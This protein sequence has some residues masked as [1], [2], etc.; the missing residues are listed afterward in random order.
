MFTR[1]SLV[2]GSVLTA[3]ALAAACEPPF[4]P[5]FDDPPLKKPVQT[6]AP[7]PQVATVVA[8]DGKEETIEYTVVVPVLVRE[9]FGLRAEPHWVPDD[10]GMWVS[11]RKTPTVVRWQ[12]K[13]ITR[14][15]KIDRLKFSDATG[16]QLT[17]EQVWKR[18]AIGTTFFVSAD[19]APVPSAHLALIA[20]DV[21][22][23]VDFDNVLM[24]RLIQ[25]LELSGI[26]QGI[27]RPLPH[28]DPRPK[29]PELPLL[30]RPKPQPELR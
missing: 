3:A 22:V 10:G 20:R 16:K 9:P 30:P 2:L 23:V 24:E 25:E 17:K 13:Q 4:P 18:L 5:P 15:S 12:Y 27:E 19:G 26:D 14:K 29:L 11:L 21:L 7:F 6:V 8:L 28:P 1:V